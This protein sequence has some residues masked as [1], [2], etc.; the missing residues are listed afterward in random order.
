MARKVFVSYKYSDAVS[1]RDKIIKKLSN[2]GTYYKGEKG[3]VK[4]EYA[5]STM[6]N[7]LSGLI[8]DSTVTVVIISPEV[9]L[10]DWVKWEL[11]YSMKRQTRNGRT[12]N[13]NGIVCVIQNRV[14]YSSRKFGS[15]S[16]NENSQWAYT[17]VG[18]NKTLNKNYFPDII[19][20][21]MQTT[22]SYN[23]YYGFTTSRT[24]SDS[25]VDTKD[26]CIVVSESTFLN[27]PDKYIEEA[28]KRA[29]DESYTVSIR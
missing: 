25:N 1:T 11:E 26:Y 12:S 28:Y 17:R 7:Y 3:Y 6:K 15:Y 13:R 16:Y 5:D 22:F 23:N 18:Y 19:K 21:N 9:T 8:Y 10:S 2:N 27:N 24:F 4:L 14:D 29:N 20:R